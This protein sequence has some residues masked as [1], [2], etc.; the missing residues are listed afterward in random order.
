[1]Y[2][3]H[4]VAVLYYT[5]LYSTS[6]IRCAWHQINKRICIC[7]YT[8]FSTSCDA[9]QATCILPATVCEVYLLTVPPFWCCKVYVTS[10]WEYVFFNILTNLTLCF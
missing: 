1:M 9:M 6:C 2:S 3:T 8:R 7:V 5:K 10:V 4:A